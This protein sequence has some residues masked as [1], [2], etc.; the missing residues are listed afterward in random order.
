LPNSTHN[1]KEILQRSGLSALLLQFTNGQVDVDAH[2]ETATM[3]NQDE[4][5]NHW[6][7]LAEQLGL[8][9]EKPAEPVP[10]VSDRAAPLSEAI[11]HYQE[12]ETGNF[13]ESNFEEESAFRQDASF[14][15]P[16]EKREETESVEAPRDTAMEAETDEDTP[17]TSGEIQG[18]GRHRRRRRSKPETET[19]P[20]EAGQRAD[21][22]EPPAD[23][24][25]SPRRRGRRRGRRG[26][27][28]EKRTPRRDTPVAE[29]KDSIPEL[30]SRVEDEGDLDDL[31]NWQAPS[32]QELI[33]SLYR[34][35]R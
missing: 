3:S 34:P 4:R 19:A 21:E 27:D 23:E 17:E 29:S 30:E 31:S 33:A 22:S 9:P 25:D 5:R 18:R 1:R 24:D 28:A 13:A 20:G 8:E 7:E 6:Q 26:G 12:F 32:W 16:V 2:R 10:A 14:P 11:D 35:D 15:T